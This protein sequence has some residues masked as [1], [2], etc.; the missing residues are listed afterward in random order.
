MDSIGEEN[1]RT[2]VVGVDTH[3]A[4]HVAAAKDALGHDVAEAR[5]EATAHGYEDLR[6]W[7]K[8]LGE[9]EAFG[10]EGP[11]SYGMGL[12]RHLASAGEAVVEVGRPSREHRA[13]QGKS[14]PADARAAAAAVL[15]GDALGRP[16]SADGSVEM[17][18]TLRLTRETA[19]RARSVAVA[20][21]QSVLV[22]APDEVRERFAGMTS[23]RLVRAC[24]QL[25]H[26]T[27][28][29]TLADAALCALG[30]LARRYEALE[31]EAASLDAQIEALV[32]ARAPELLDLPS[33]GPQIA[34]A[35]LVTLG[36]NPERIGSERAFAKLCGVARS[37]LLRA[38]RSDTD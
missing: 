24:A 38:S 4:F 20:T 22:T 18:R 12:A 7:A 2:I 34:A 17:I 11:G 6:M 36:D 14:D 30:N 33:V 8:D 21:L 29:R 1:K 13:R 31:A 32:R 9:V 27:E 5:F 19:V 26:V 16:K 23:R 10:I 3:K 28:P 37:M 25:A 15:A 35:L